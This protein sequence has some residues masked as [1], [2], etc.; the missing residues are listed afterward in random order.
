MIVKNEAHVIE[1]SLRSVLGLI[2]WWVVSDTGSTDGTQEIVRRVLGGLPGELIEREWVSFGHNRQQALDAARALSA[3]N[4]DDYVLW[5][6]ADEVL[7]DLPETLPELTAD[8]YHLP[9]EFSGVH[10]SRLGLIRLDR[11]WTWTGAIHEHL[12]LP[13]AV[14]GQLDAPRYF[15][16]KEG[17][18]S[19]D[20]DTYR[21]DA[22]VIEAELAR[23]PDDPRL[24]FYLAQSWRDAGDHERALAAYLVRSENETGWVQ[25]TYCARFEAALCLERLGRAPAEAV[26]MHL[27]AYAL[28]P[29]RAEA[30]VQ[31]A[32]L[33]RQ[34]GRYPIALLYAREA[35]R[36][37]HP[38]AEALFVDAATYTWRALDELAVNC[39]FTGYRAEGEAAARRALA[40]HPTDERLQANLTWFTDHP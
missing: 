24:Q 14:V 1:R 32:R 13:D 39:W 40:V 25:E 12:A 20:P 2:D 11:P 27:S 3:S 33:E 8:G 21:K 9:V 31:A 34:Q 15:V 29:N 38:G 10:Y 19:L 36:L 30:L 28:V 7:T 35:A 5:I 22:A 6:D 16:R 37:P 23:T 17:A 26:A 4:A 18:R